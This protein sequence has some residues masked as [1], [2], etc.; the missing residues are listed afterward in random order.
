[1]TDPYTVY[2]LLYHVILAQ[3]FSKPVYVMPNSFGP[4]KGIGVEWLVRRVMN[5]CK[6]VAV[7]ESISKEMVEKIGV[8]TILM[9]DLGFAL[10]KSSNQF[11]EIEKIQ[12]GSNKNIMP[13]QL[14]AG[15][16]IPALFL[17]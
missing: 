8:K 12:V 9:P 3:S 1:M 10:S 17:F 13:K 11:P 2:Y 7:R 6:I 4:F 14:F 16:S 15:A 5:K